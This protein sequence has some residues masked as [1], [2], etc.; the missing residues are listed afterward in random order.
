M[1]TNPVGLDDCT[2]DSASSAFFR[3]GSTKIPLTKFTPP[4]DEIKT[5]RVRRAG[6]MRARKRTPGVSEVSDISVELL[7][8]D[9][10]TFIL[11]RMGRHGGTLIEFI[12]TASVFHPS[13][14][15]SYGILC[16]GGRIVTSEGPEFAMDEKG[17]I[18]KLGISVI[19]VWERG[20]DGVWKTLALKTPQMASSLAQAA[21]QF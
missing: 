5:E 14:Q 8:S 20:D 18:K 3:F 19:D 4:K 11:P 13:V 16:D 17:L 7:A 9:Y 15:G 6:E 21:M 10:K 12:I 1:P 2:W